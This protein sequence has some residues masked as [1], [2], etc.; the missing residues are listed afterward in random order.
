MDRQDVLLQIVNEKLDLVLLKLDAVLRR[1]KAM[2]VQLDHLKTQ[3]E[4]AT[5]VSQSAVTLIGGL[6]EQIRQLKD[7]PAMLEQLAT[8]LDAQTS[9]LAAA[10]QANTTPTPPPAPTP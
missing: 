10:V 1:E 2:S 6:A 9:A 4:R 8:D 3:V 5:S 7:D